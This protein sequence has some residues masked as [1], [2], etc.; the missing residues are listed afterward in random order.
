MRLQYLSLLLL[1]IFALVAVSGCALLIGVTPTPVPFEKFGAQDV[2]NAFARASLQMQNPEKSMVV[3][4]RGAP[5]EFS[6]RYVFEVPRIAPAGGQIVVFA[7][8]EQM[9]A[10][11]DYIE[12]LRNNSETRRDV[13]FVYF[14]QNVMLQLNPQLTNQEAFA[15]RDAF[16]GM[17]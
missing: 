7:D 9:Q 4:G 14:N 12:R 3:E 11:Q 5:G 17:T 15:Y 13:V 1:A 6:D 8:A 2:F 16:M 10:W